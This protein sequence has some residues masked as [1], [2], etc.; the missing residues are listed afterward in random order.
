MVSERINGLISDTLRYRNLFRRR[1]VGDAQVG[2]VISEMVER[3]RGVGFDPGYGK[4]RT[5]CLADLVVDEGVCQSSEEARLA[6]SAVGYSKLDW[7]STVHSCTIICFCRL[8]VAGLVS[9]S[10][11]KIGTGSHDGQ[12]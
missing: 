5:F 12:T 11:V 9:C 10:S 1:V 4:G 8:D 3:C 7:Y 2:R 6:G